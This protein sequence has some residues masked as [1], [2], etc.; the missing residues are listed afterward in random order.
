MS[1]RANQIAVSSAYNQPLRKH[2]AIAKSA[3]DRIFAELNPT[4]K[5]KND[6]LEF[7]ADYNVTPSLN[8]TSQTGYNQDFLY[9]P[10]K[11]TIGSTVRQ[12]PRFDL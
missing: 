4:Y 5:A 9:G 1:S 8:F 12:A 11:I 6:T 3:G 10:R 7:N 2:D